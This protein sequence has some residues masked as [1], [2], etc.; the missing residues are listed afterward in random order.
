M[1]IWSSIAS[2]SATFVNIIAINQHEQVLARLC[3][4]W[5]VFPMKGDK[6]TTTDEMFDSALTLSRKSGIVDAGG[7]VVISAGVPIGK[8]GG[9]N[10]IKIQQL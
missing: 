10:L 7:Y 9:T 2:A 1:A 5:G 4:L 3:L 8:S 6:V